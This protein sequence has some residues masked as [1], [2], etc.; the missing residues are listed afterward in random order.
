MRLESREDVASADVSRI[1]HGVMRDVHAVRGASLLQKMLLDAS[2]PSER[3]LLPH[4]FEERS[5]CWGATAWPLQLSVL[6]GPVRLVGPDLLGDELA[7][8]LLCG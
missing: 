7:R 2:E 5:N 4:Y 6:N 8:P 1:T 3:E